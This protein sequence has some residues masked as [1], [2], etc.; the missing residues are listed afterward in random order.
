MV[1]DAI[2]KHTSLLV[3]RILHILVLAVR[4][5]ELLVNPHQQQVY[6]EEDIIQ[7]MSQMC[8]M[9]LLII[10]GIGFVLGLLVVQKIAI[11]LLQK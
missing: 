7:V 1:M 9:L 6:V 3:L 5:M 10:N 4:L 2:R 8:S 11:V